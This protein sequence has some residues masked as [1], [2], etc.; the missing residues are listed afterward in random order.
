ME[1]DSNPNFSDFCDCHCSI[2]PPGIS[3]RFGVRNPDFGVRMDQALVLPG[4]SY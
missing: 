3:D 2:P 4:L 1:N